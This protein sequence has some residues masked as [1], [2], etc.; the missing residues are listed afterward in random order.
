MIWPFSR[1]SVPDAPADPQVTDHHPIPDHY[2]ALYPLGPMSPGLRLFYLAYAIAW[3]LLLPV[4]ALYMLH[5]ARKDPAWRSHW[6]ERLGGGP[7]M[8]GA[9]WVH[10]VS[11]GEMRAA[12]PLIRTL[13]DRGAQ[14]VTTHLTP[15]GR[16][17]AQRAFGPEIRA[18]RLV[19]CYVPIETGWA[20]RRFLRRLRPS[21]ALVMEQEIWPAMIENARR[22]GVGLYLCNSQITHRGFAK[23]QSLHRLTG[24][25]VSRISGV[26]AKSA[27]H[28]ANFRALG[29]PRAAVC[30]EVRFDQA[31]PPALT[32][33]AQRLRTLPRAALGDRPIV[34]LASCV[35][36]EEEIY[37]DV[38]EALRTSLRA[39]GRA[40]PLLVFVPRALER[41]DAAAACAQA[42]G[43][44]VVRRSDVLGQDLEALTPAALASA[45]VL[46]GDS[47][48]EMYF[49][50]ALADAVITGGGFLPQGA[51]NVI[52]ALQLGKPV[53]VGPEIWTIEFPAHEAAAAGVLE[54]CPDASS[55]ADRLGAMLDGHTHPAAHRARAAAFLAGYGGVPQRML[56]TLSDWG[57][58]I[59]TCPNSPIA[60][61][62]QT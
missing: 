21:L 36:G 20:Y 17:E 50:L 55:M 15:A 48:G 5:R 33:A 35:A 51:H 42:R 27:P 16:R 13:L 47:M 34:T 29:A 57:V 46:L 6:S 37:L 39:A 38:F 28:A 40:D 10:A 54:I 43:L 18:G 3:H 14:V 23:A 31:V 26:L 22:A 49:Y 58:P 4:V 56:G 32:E 11:L 45:D 12:I 2:A 24:H 8:S 25:P 1:S 59:P 7:Q 52:E 19:P 9:I 41:F 60:P 30:G 61:S 44:H 53:L 62:Q